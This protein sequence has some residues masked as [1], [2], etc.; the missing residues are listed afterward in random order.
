M[1][2]NFTVKKTTGLCL[3]IVM[4]FSIIVFNAQKAFSATRTVYWKSMPIKVCI[5][6]NQY[7]PLMT[8]AFQEWQ[9]VTSNRVNFALTCNS[10]QITISYAPK[11]IRSVTNISFNHL[12]EI[13]KAHIEM[14]LLTQQ[15]KPANDKT[16]LLVMEHEIAH[17][18]GIQGHTN[19]PKSIMQPTVKEDYTIT[20]DTLDQLKKLYK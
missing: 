2:R 18:L 9:R 5:P 14:A 17:A 3:A 4:L 20:Q 16:L 1:T 8:K 7:K 12:G 19:T 6:E 13:T 10:P 11:K 15:G